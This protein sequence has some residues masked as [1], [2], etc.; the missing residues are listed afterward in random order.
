MNVNYEIVC[1]REGCEYV[2]IGETGR[3]AY[4]RGRE[5]LKGMERECSESVLVEHIRDHHGSDMSE[6]PCHKFKMN[7]T[8]CHYTALDR[9]VTEAVKIDTSDRTV[10]NR[11]QG[12]RVNSVLKLSTSL[13]NNTL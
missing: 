13:G 1:T 11:K 4:C 9:L 10:M 5:H 2:Y 6:P 8:S 7:V 3:N 12:F